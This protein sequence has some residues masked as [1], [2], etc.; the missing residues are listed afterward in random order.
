MSG[1]LDFGR[2]LKK[3]NSAEKHGNMFGREEWSR[4]LVGETNAK[5]RVT[6]FKWS[7]LMRNLVGQPHRQNK[8]RSD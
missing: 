3:K 8:A 5:Y 4:M 7:A 6:R 2:L 1:A